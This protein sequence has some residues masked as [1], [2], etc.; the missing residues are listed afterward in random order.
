M[1]DANV[2]IPSVLRDTLLR[3][4][5][6]ELYMVRWSKEI[7]D[8]MERNLVAALG[9]D[10]EKAARLRRHMERVFPEAEVVGYGRHEQNLLN[11]S[12]DRHV[13]AVALESRA[14]LVVTH[15]LRDFVPMPE[16]IAAV[17]PDVFLTQV[18]A[19]CPNAVLRL[20][21]SQARDM[22]RPPVTLD[23]LLGW[24]S[25]SCPQF[26]EAVRVHRASGSDSNEI[27]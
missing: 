23:A 25:R 8:E 19:D 1:L 17:S 3:G 26:V 21:A 12:K 22:T 2:L 27:D 15:N 4:V 18:I 13:V 16:G 9:L 10:P 6:A 24:L 11:D 14:S 5:D 7:L 20:L